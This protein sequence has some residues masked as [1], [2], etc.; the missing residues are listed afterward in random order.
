MA[1]GGATTT[2][3]SISSKYFPASGSPTTVPPPF[4]SISLPTVPPKIVTQPT[5]P[6]TNPSSH[7]SLPPVPSMH[8]TTVPPFMPPKTLFPPPFTTP[9]PHEVPSYIPPIRSYFT[10]PL[11]PDYANPFADKPTLRGSNSDGGI[12]NAGRRPIPPPPRPP[13]G[14]DRIPWRPPD[15]VPNL[16]RDGSG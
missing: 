3:R 9:T 16:E 4:T 15:M 14:R 10:P 8:P 2:K 6:Y 1:Y 13:S 12:P 7:K 11:P 5:L